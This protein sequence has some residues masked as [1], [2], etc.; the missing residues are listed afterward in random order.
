MAQ[1][2]FSGE[3][4]YSLPGRR[5]GGDRG[6][7]R[8]RRAG[9]RSARSS[10]RSPA[11]APAALAAAPKLDRPPRPAAR[12]GLRSAALA[13]DLA[14]AITV[15]RRPGRAA[16]LRA[17]VRRRPARAAA[18]LP[19]RRREAARR[20]R[21]AA[22]GRRVPLPPRARTAASSRPPGPASPRWRAEAGAGDRSHAELGSPKMRPNAPPWIALV[23]VVARA[24]RRGGRRRRAPR[25]ARRDR[26]RRRRPPSAGGRTRSTS[27]ASR[28]ASTGRP[29]S[30]PRP[31]IRGA[32]GARAARPRRPAARR[33]PRHGRS[34]SR[35]QVHDRRRAG[36]ARHRVPS[37]LRHQPAGCY[38][39]WSDERGDT[40]VAEFRDGRQVRE[41]LFVDQPEEN[42]N[43]GQL[44]FGPDGRLYVGLGDGGGA[45]DPERRAQDPRERLGKLLSIDVEAPRRDWRVELIGLRNPWRFAFDPALGEV[46]IGDVG[47]DRVE[48]VDR[49]L[50]EPDE[51]PKN[52]GWSAFEGDRARVRGRRLAGRRR[53]RLA[54]RAVHARRRLLGHRRLRLPGHARSPAARPLPLRRL[55]LGRPVVAAGRAGGPRRPT[56]GASARAVPQL[57]HIGPDARRRAAVR[58]GHRRDLPRGHVRLDRA[59]RAVDPDA[60][61]VARVPRREARAGGCAA[62]ARSAA[63]GARAGRARRTSARTTTASACGSRPGAGA[64]R[65]RLRAD[66]D[67]DPPGQAGAAPKRP[68]SHS[69]TPSLAVPGQH[70]GLAEELGQPAAVRA[71]VDLLRRADLLDRARR[72]SPRRCR[73]AT[74]PRPGRA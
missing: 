46:W 50:L 38:L 41:L 52:L 40:R 54:G 64:D 11:V 5:A 12:P 45:F 51:P 71:L 28:P 73:P 48:E 23:G 17:A 25:P 39:H 47:Q 20:V 56:C 24:R 65:D 21:S 53:A 26:P 55:L 2:G 43:G 4:R 60:H 3:P 32:V 72:A 16:G 37:R 58:L 27:S 61:A 14:R 22:A 6:R 67:L 74:A 10:R 7:R 18:R 8:P 13:A 9:A 29:G 59:D 36:A 62:A 49:V 30:A 15:G 63:P 19:P 57:T 35:P 68:S 42:H 44:A 66:H 33:P 1:A 69:T 31:A 34:T 70:V